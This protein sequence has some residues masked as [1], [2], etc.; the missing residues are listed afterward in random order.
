RV[1]RTALAAL[2]ATSTT[3]NA[4]RA[5]ERS[6]L[7]ATRTL[8]SC[9]VGNAGARRGR[10]TCASRGLRRRRVDERPFVVVRAAFVEADRLG[11]A[12]ARHAEDAADG[13]GLTG[14]SG[15]RDAGA[16]LLS[17]ARLLSSLSRLITAALLLPGLREGHEVVV[18]DG[19]LVLLAEK[20][21][22]HE[23][24]EVR[25]VGVRGPA[26]E[27]S[28]RVCV[29]L[30]SKYELFFF[31]TLRHVL[32]HGHGRSHQDGHDR[33]RHDQGGHRVA[34]FTELTMPLTR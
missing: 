5:L 13:S 14:S 17:A 3:R 19:V 30:A 7:V 6:R 28:D 20:L 31:L 11:R 33:H 21:L 16:G 8:S 27:H 9:R 26:L 15:T 29:L 10:T 18:G 34:T 25:W 23:H 24:V 32:P 4:A 12:F 2:A 1:R 22:L